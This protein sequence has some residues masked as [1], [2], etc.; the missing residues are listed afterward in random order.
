[1]LKSYTI[2]GAGD[3]GAGDA[4]VGPFGVPAAGFVGGT[5]ARRAS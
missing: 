4:R 3:L 1:M 2:P 5:S